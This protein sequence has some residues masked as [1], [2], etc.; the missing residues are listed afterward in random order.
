MVDMPPAMDLYGTVLD[1]FVNNQA[2]EYAGDILQHLIKTNGKVVA[3][4][5][6]V[7]NVAIR[8]CA[9]SGETQIGSHAQWLFNTDFACLCH[10]KSTH[11][12]RCCDRQ[13]YCLVV[14]MPWPY[15]RHPAGLHGTVVYAQGSQ[16]MTRILLPSTISYKSLLH[17]SANGPTVMLKLSPSPALRA[18]KVLQ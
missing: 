6:T 13:H 16:N 7:L 2:P 15:H 18:S 3:A 12:A 14:G 11:T 1:A 17:T 10:D 9:N 4:D 5:T 8:E